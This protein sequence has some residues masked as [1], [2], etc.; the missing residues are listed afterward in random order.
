VRNPAQKKAPCGQIPMLTASKSTR[1]F[2]DSAQFCVTFE[3]NFVT[4]AQFGISFAPFGVTFAWCAFLFGFYIPF[5]SLFRY[6]FQILAI[7]GI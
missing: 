6:F 1:H 2:A 4:F 7:F 5:R 3:A